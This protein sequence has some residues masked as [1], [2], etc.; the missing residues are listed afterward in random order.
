[1]VNL[2]D[3][4]ISYPCPA[5][6]N[7]MEGDERVRFCSQCKLNVYNISEMSKDDARDLIANKEG[8]G[9][10]CIRLYRRP[11][12]T[13]ITDNCP[14]GLKAFRARVR[15]NFIALAIWVF[16][17][18]FVSWV[19]VNLHAD[20]YTIISGGMGAPAPLPLKAGTW[21]IIGSFLTTQ[22]GLALISIHEQWRQ[23]WMLSTALTFFA[24]LAF[25]GLSSMGIA[26]DPIYFAVF[27]LPYGIIFAVGSLVTTLLV[28]NR[29][30]FAPLT[31]YF[32]FR[33]QLPPCQWPAQLEESN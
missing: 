27:M 25:G 29:G 3:I 16:G 15:T 19:A 32:D 18:A 5:N 10:L 33:Q 4:S 14:V 11:D 13:V 8:E 31:K 12:G 26:F 6:W 2:D 30:H 1:V 9:Q 23:Q 22:I 28:L 24:G 7:A 20:R 21:V 17:I